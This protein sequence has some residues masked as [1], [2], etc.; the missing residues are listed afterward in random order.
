MTKKA[1]PKKLKKTAKPKA[2]KAKPE[3]F[4]TGTKILGRGMAQG[5]L[6]LIEA[7]RDIAEASQ[8]ITG[9]CVGYKLF[10][11]KLIPSMERNDMRA[12]YRLLLTAREQGIIPWEWIVDET[13]ASNG[14]RHGTMSSSTPVSSLTATASTSG[15]S[16][17]SA[18][19]SGPKRAPCA[20]CLRRCST[21]TLLASGCCTDLA[22]LRRSTMLRRMTTAA[23]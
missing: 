22:A 19:K 5:S 13:A 23:N 18:S 9:R 16:S 21:V 17:R 14:S 6:D 3:H 15:I 11:Q 10:V 4:G 2:K 1:K 7:M 12:V 20:A 8:P